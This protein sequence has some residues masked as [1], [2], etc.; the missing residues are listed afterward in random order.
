MFGLFKKKVSL[1]KVNQFCEWFYQNNERIIQ[2]VSQAGKDN[3]LMMYVL[4]EVENALSKVYRDG[5]KGSIEFEYGFNSNTQKWD[6]FLYHMNNKYLIEATHMIATA[7]E[8]K[9]KD[10]W[11]IHIS[12]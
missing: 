11:S 10:I 12:E 7:L 9:M 3:S 1:E 2:S 8:A 5:Y 6:L 4:D